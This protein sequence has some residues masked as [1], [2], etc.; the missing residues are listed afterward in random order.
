MVKK[1]RS[2]NA[3]V[4]DVSGGIDIDDRGRTINRDVPKDERSSSSRKKSKARDEMLRSKRKAKK[5]LEDEKKEEEKKKP[6][7]KAVITKDTAD[8]KKKRK[9]KAKPSESI[10]D[11]RKKKRKKK[12]VGE[13][14]EK[15]TPRSRRA[16]EKKLARLG[17]AVAKVA[18]DNEQ[19][20]SVFGDSD[21]RVLPAPT[22]ESDYQAEYDHIFTTLSTISR[23]L[24]KRMGETV[25][26]KDVYAL[27]TLY[28]QMRETIADLRSISDVN[29]QADMLIAEALEPYHKTVGEA[30][31]ATY[32][33]LNTTL[34][35]SMS[36]DMAHKLGE[37]LKEIVSEQALELQS[38]FDSTKEKV[39]TILTASR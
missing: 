25:S 37:R 31:V 33:K 24:E 36:E 13:L 18:D 8:N 16:A 11:K 35:Q 28:S 7:S 30:L 14:L 6:K 32:F 3:S 19:E 5:K 10:N 2:G 29:Q 1:R 12:T 15:D 4:I 23:N 22:S 17:K 26:S 27:S 34:R 21:V 38:Q 20:V 9:K 39:A